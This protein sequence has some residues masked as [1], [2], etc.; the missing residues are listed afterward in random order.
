ATG[1]TSWC[2]P[3]KRW[4]GTSRRLAV[5]RCVRPSR[6]CAH[7]EVEMD[8]LVGK[9]HAAFGAVDNAGIDERGH[10]PV[11]GLHVAAD[12]P[13]DLADRQRALPGKRLDDGKAGGGENAVHVLVAAEIEAG[14]N[15]DVLTGKHL[16]AGRGDPAADL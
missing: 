6:R 10:V 7:V 2:G 11:D 15:I 13:G 16:P 1:R 9:L 3:A 12:A 5:Q 14:L 4:P 8:V